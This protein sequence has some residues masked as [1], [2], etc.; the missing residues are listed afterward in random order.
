MLFFF[1]LALFPHYIYDYTFV[2]ILYWL[3]FYFY[4]FPYL[5]VCLFF[6]AWLCFALLCARWRAACSSGKG[7]AKA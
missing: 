7:K 5:S 6:L 1:L 3:L 2:F 4:F